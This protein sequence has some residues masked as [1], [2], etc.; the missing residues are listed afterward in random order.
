M[1]TAMIT[2][3]DWIDAP[4]QGWAGLR[5]LL[6]RKLARE[7][8]RAGTRK[9]PVGSL[10]YV[11]GDG[12]RLR[13]ASWPADLEQLA[14]QSRRG[15]T[16]VVRVGPQ[17]GGMDSAASAAQQLLFGPDLD[18]SAVEAE[19][20][21]LSKGDPSPAGGCT[22]PY[23]VAQQLHAKLRP[24]RWG[25]F[26]AMERIRGLCT[27]TRLLALGM[28]V[29]RRRVEL[30]SFGMDAWT[31]AGTG[32]DVRVN[33][34]KAE[35]LGTV[36]AS[37]DEVHT[38]LAAAVATIPGLEG[39]R[40]FDLSTLCKSIRVDG[41][42]SRSDSV[43]STTL[44][45]A[46]GDWVGE[47]LLE[48]VPGSYLT[49]TPRGGWT[50]VHLDSATS[51]VLEAIKLGLDVDSKTF[52]RAFATNMCMVR[53]TNSSTTYPNDGGGKSKSKR[54]F[55]NPDSA[56]SRV[57]FSIH[58]AALLA[59]FR[60]NMHVNLQLGLPGEFLSFVATSC[61][62]PT[63]YDLLKPPGTPL[64]RH[65][66]PRS[67]LGSRM[68]VLGFTDQESEI[69]DKTSFQ[70]P[71]G[72]LTS[73]CGGADRALKF[74]LCTE[75]GSLPKRELG[76]V[77]AVF[78]GRNTSKTGGGDPLVI[79]LEFGADDRIA[80]LETM[81]DLN[82]FP[83]ELVQGLNAVLPP[84]Q[85]FHLF[86]SSAPVEALDLLTAKDLAYLLRSAYAASAARHHGRPSVPP[87]PPPC[88]PDAGRAH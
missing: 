41:N 53:L 27:A 64:L 46:Q 37:L 15:V 3:Q 80:A 13:S 21:A 6:A 73:R 69:G 55:F 2:A 74:Q 8:E 87:S 71:G 36:G 88:T 40:N 31:R 19:L 75:I 30:D 85:H 67:P 83:N 68:S 22:H 61:P 78:V 81:Y 57:A 34:L 26:L 58:V 65:L 32:I 1:H 35:A 39:S 77:H 9:A 5:W 10:E 48:L 47:L 79:Y 59:V 43:C 25:A 52:R 50:E 76:A 16:C 14:E 28:V 44:I 18:W 38:T 49:L 62:R 86:A 54:E 4:F 24:E 84:G 70:L 29:E 51:G 33:D 63:L 23:R 60:S 7:F 66:A 20:T 45:L 17:R 82:C 42:L 56:S 11:D 72:W 12:K